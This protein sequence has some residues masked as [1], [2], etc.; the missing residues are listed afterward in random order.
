[1]GFSR[2]E[3]WSGLPCPPPE[4]LPNPGIELRSPALQV[5]SL[6]SEPPRK[7]KEP[8]KPSFQTREDQVPRR[9]FPSAL[10]FPSLSPL[11]HTHWLLQRIKRW[12]SDNICLILI[13]VG[14]FGSW[15]KGEHPNQLPVPSPKSSRLCALCLYFSKNVHDQGGPTHFGLRITKAAQPEGA[16]WSR[17]NPPRVAVS[18]SLLCLDLAWGLTFPFTV[19]SESYP[20]LLPATQVSSQTLQSCGRS[21]NSCWLTWLSP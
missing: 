13:V 9:L 1:M 19:S 8:S 5:D 6:T 2:P 4:D 10:D 7:P 15:G 12:T 11:V 17:I 3:Y 14:P 16:D 21:I 20:G 18:S